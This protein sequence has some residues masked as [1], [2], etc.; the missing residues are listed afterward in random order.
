M[1][2]MVKKGVEAKDKDEGWKRGNKLRR[3]AYTIHVQPKREICILHAKQLG[4]QRLGLLM[5][6]KRNRNT[7]S[8]G[9]GIS[10]SN[11]CAQNMW[12]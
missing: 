9:S 1:S 8:G 5:L 6:V 4:V 12:S 11:L 7:C 2:K 10:R 3:S